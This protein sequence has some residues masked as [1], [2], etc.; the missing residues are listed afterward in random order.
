MDFEE[1]VHNS[2]RIAVLN[3]TGTV[4]KS[5]IWERVP[6]TAIQHEKLGDG[7]EGKEVDWEE[8]ASFFH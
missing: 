2:D 3:K 5:S 4:A 1:G 7:P 6:D 8:R